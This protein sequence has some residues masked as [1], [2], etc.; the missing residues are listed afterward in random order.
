VRRHV[1]PRHQARDWRQ[2]DTVSKLMIDAGEALAAYQDAAFADLATKRVQVDE[3]WSFTYAKQ[4]NVAD[5]K[6][7]P[8]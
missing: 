7:A 4:K 6:D 3:I 5:A 2:Q 1:D 8:E